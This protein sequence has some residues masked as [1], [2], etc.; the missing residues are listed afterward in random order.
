MTRVAAVSDRL[1]GY[2][3]RN[4]RNVAAAG[5]RVA[6]TKLKANTRI[7]VYKWGVSNRYQEAP[8]P[9]LP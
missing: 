7:V 8:V 6:A 1:A 5:Y 3:R 9:S 2:R 4:H